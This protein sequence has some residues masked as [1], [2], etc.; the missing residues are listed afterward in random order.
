MFVHLAKRITMPNDTPLT[1]CTWNSIDG[2]VSAGCIDGLV[3]VLKLEVP[4]S[5]KRKIF[6]KEGFKSRLR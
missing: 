1:R 3:K 4:E 5:E 2:L 6:L